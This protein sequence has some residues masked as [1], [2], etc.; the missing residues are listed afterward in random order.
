MQCSLFIDANGDDMIDKKEIFEDYKLHLMLYNNGSLPAHATDDYLQRV[1][2][3][4]MWDL[5]RDQDQLLS[6]SECIGIY[7]PVNQTALAERDCKTEDFN[8]D[9]MI[10]ATEI[11][12]YNEKV[13]SFAWTF[14][15]PTDDCIS[16][17][18]KSLEICQK[19]ALQYWMENEHFPLVT[20]AIA[21]VESFTI[22]ECITGALIMMQQ[23]NMRPCGGE[24]CDDAT[25]DISSEELNDDSNEAFEEIP[26]DYPSEEPNETST[27]A[28]ADDP[29][30]AA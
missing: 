28:P 26:T 24:A 2:K 16:D 14:C 11:I 23:P 30:V 27:E 4:V 25:T 15:K 3:G 6:I 21:P 12:E 13:A 20:D 29:V 22:D 9:G 7:K 5:D 17:D 19:E 8:K 1:A 18:S 10:T